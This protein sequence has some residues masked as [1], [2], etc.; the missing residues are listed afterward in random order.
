MALV[1]HGR[2]GHGPLVAI[3]VVLAYG[4]GTEMKIS[5]LQLGIMAFCSAFVTL[6]G[7]VCAAPFASAQTSGTARATVP[8]RSSQLARSSGSVTGSSEPLLLVHGYTDNCISAFSPETINSNTQSPPAGPKGLAGADQAL[9][10][11]RFTNLVAVGYYTNETN[12]GSNSESANGCLS[13]AAAPGAKQTAAVT[14]APDVG[15]TPSGADSSSDKCQSIPHTHLDGSTKV[16]DTGTINDPIRH[17]ACRL[18]WYIYD[19]YTKNGLSVRILAHSMGGLVVRDA[20]A[21][22]GHVSPFPPALLMVDRVVTVA[23]PHGGLNDQYLANANLFAPSTEVNDMAVGSAFMNLMD[24]NQDPQGAGGTFWGL[25]GGS[26]SC[27]SAIPNAAVN[28]MPLLVQQIHPSCEETSSASGGL[29]YTGYTSGDG[30]VQASSQLGMKADVKVLYGM[31]D[32]VDSQG[33]LTSDTADAATQYGHEWHSGG[34]WWIISAYIQGPFYLNDNGTTLTKAWVCSAACAST[35]SSNPLGDMNL[36]NNTAIAVSPALGEM[37]QLL[38]TPGFT[39]G[40]AKLAGN[41]YPYDGLGQFEHQSLNDP[42]HEYDGQCDSFAA[43]KVYENLGGT[44][45]ANPAM[46]PD[47]SFSPTDKGISP[48][49]GYAGAGAP[50]SNWGDAKDWGAKA[51]SLGYTVDDNP[52]PGSIAWWSDNGTGMSVGHVGYV[53]D[54]Y[55]DGS[56]TIESY[57]L[58]VNGEYSV[59]HMNQNGVDDTSFNLPAFHVVWPTGFIHIG[60]SAANIVQPPQPA[61]SQGWGYPHNT[62]GPGSGGSFT[63]AGSAYPNTVH[64]WYTDTGHGDIGDEQWTNTHPGAAD[65]TATWSP[66][67]AADACYEIDTFVPD[68]WS[69]NAAALYQVTDLYFG[70]SLVPV[71]ENKT[72]NDWVSLGVFKAHDDGTLPVTLVDQGAGGGQVAADAMRFIQQAN[73]DGVVRTSATAAY[74]NGMA[75]SGSPYPGTLDGWY[76]ASGH[77]QLGDE[78]YTYTNGMTSSSSASWTAWVVPSACY[79]VLAYVPDEYS[80]DYQAI[81]TVTSASG[82]TPTVTIDENAYTNNFASLGVY[83]ATSGGYLDVALTDQSLKNGDAYVAADTMSFVNI[84]CPSTVEGATYPALTE[85]PGSPLSQFSL[86]SDW[87][88]RFG[89]GDLGYEKWTNTN[90]STAVS[91]ATWTFTGLPANTTYYACAY[92]PDNYANNTAAH[93]QGFVGTSTSPYFFTYINQAATTGWMILGL[94]YTDTTGKLTVTLDDTGSPAGSYTA[95]DAIRLQ[96]TYPC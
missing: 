90:G 63:L 31:V 35:A 70:I 50:A 37:A 2:M 75:L 87:Y 62:Y 56:V 16:D 67:L 89:H 74:G 29:L 47:A 55:P 20:I 77:G 38:S 81:Y 52:S 7:L 13:T 95:A 71:D 84:A 15:S 73:C 40:H 61:P 18:A 28:S 83:R 85:G 94:L 92:I 65:S 93:Y 17:I 25:I 42:W 66:S 9:T 12:Q 69:N 14:D 44:A 79:E 4:E 72:T 23:T 8:I 6:A 27:N 59:I 80:N 43:W 88:N 10:S 82:G 1:P 46:I 41:D 5:T 39:V 96:T 45:R 51:A 19:F 30:I 76:S 11:A 49:V 24:A 32:H 57:N 68:N 64:G 21:E 53:T 36:G 86:G 54:V 3:A 91:T 33:M 34:S 48:V 26:Q 22:S 58:R 60:D 78:Y